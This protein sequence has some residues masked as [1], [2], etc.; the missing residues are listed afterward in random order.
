[1]HTVV[2]PEMNAAVGTRISRRVSYPVA[3]SDI[4]RWALATYWPLPA[5]A[6][7]LSLDE[8]GVVAPEELNPFA[9]ASAESDRNPAARDSEPNDP[10]HT[11]KQI[12]VA[13]PG[14]MF[15]LNGGLEM[16]YLAP[17]RVGDV[18]TSVAQLG[19][20]TER[21][22]RLGHMLMTKLEDTWTNQDGRHV[23]RSTITLIRY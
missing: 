6:A 23:K 5:P 4:R 19:G 21:E 18:I 3:A 11:E 9:W 16:E 1:M 2:T 22:G 13:G 20:Y 10:D 12:G 7:Y 15:Q 8:A 14:L 17:I